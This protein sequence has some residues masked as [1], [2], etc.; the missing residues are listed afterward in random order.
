MSDTAHEE[1]TTARR[2]QWPLITACAMAVGWNDSW[3]RCQPIA[4]NPPYTSA[5]GST[6]TRRC[7]SCACSGLVHA[8]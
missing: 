2:R 6:V 7:H 4:S 1:S 3:A 5:S 8:S